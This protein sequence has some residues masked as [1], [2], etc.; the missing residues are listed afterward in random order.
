M[1][2]DLEGCKALLFRKQD[3]PQGTRNSSKSHDE[4]LPETGLER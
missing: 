4:N 3:E 2:T 1:K